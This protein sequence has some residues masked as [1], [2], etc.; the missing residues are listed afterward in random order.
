MTVPDELE[1]AKGDRLAARVAIPIIVVMIYGVYIF[2]EL[3]VSLDYYLYTY[4]PVL[5]GIA[6]LV[7]L[8]MY[9]LV[10]VAPSGK[11]RWRNLLALLGFLPYFFSLYVIGF[12]GLYTIYVAVVGPFLLWPVIAGL[13]WIALGC[14]MINR[15]YLITEIER[16]LGR[17]PLTEPLRIV[18]ALHA[19]AYMRWIETRKGQSATARD[20][21]RF[22]EG[23]LDTERLF[24]DADE[25]Q[26][27]EILA[28]S[29]NLDMV[30]AF[31]SE[32]KIFEK[33]DQAVP[34]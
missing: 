23:L 5:G 10:I 14:I 33:M 1:G 29:L 13:F 22:I 20:V 21:R 11:R 31:I 30:H 17:K 3:G 15:F 26:R 6:A 19:A 4:I 28:L 8:L 7:G 12:L 34:S 25:P 24:Y 18:A 27:I 32:N 9:Y 2:V 16:Q